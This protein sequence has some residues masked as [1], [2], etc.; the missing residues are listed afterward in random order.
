MR[1]CK[2]G[3]VWEWSTCELGFEECLLLLK[4]DGDQENTLLLDEEHETMIPFFFFLNLSKQNI[5]LMTERFILS[6]QSNK[7][8]IHVT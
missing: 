6:I 5:I 4:I 7:I 3:P 8:Y 1:G 2:G